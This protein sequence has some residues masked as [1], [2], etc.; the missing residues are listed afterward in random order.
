[1]NYIFMS[2][3]T[4]GWT[5]RARAVA[6][7]VAAWLL[8]GCA[9]LQID[10]DVYKGPL[11]NDEQIQM[12]QFAS[13]AVAAKP[14]LAHLRNDIEVAFRAERK[15]ASVAN[16]EARHKLHKDLDHH[17]TSME[18]QS[19]LATFINGALL[20]Y[21]DLGHPVLRDLEQTIRL[22]LE[23]SLLLGVG[24]QDR[25]L[26]DILR[27]AALEPGTDA[28]RRAMALALARFLC[29]PGERA[30][31]GTTCSALS[32][33]AGAS[34]EVGNPLRRYAG[35]LYAACRNL[36]LALSA[37]SPQAAA[38]RCPDVARSNAGFAFVGDPVNVRALSVLLL[39]AE[40][41]ELSERLL[42]LG[43]AFL[44]ARVHMRSAFEA[45]LDLL[46]AVN[47]PVQAGPRARLVSQLMQ[48][49]ITACVLTSPKGR[50]RQHLSE[51]DR[52]VA[53]RLDRLLQ[54]NSAM[55]EWG[56]SEF[57]RANAAV[58]DVAL[59]APAS[60]ARVF[61]AAH[62]A[63][64]SYSADDLARC[65]ALLKDS[66]AHQRAASS[67]SRQFGA[68]RG[69]DAD[70][71]FLASLESVKLTLGEIQSPHSVAGFDRARL[72]AGIDSLTRAYLQEKHDGMAV[73]GGDASPT[74]RRLRETLIAFAERVLFVS[75]SLT[76]SVLREELGMARDACDLTSLGPLCS[77][78]RDDAVSRI[79]PRLGLVQ[80]LGNT[81][82]LYA[83]DLVRRERHRDGQRNAGAAEAHA[84]RAASTPGLERQAAYVEQQIASELRAATE[85]RD[86]AQTTSERS[87]RAVA[88]AEQDAQATKKLADQANAAAVDAARFAQALAHAVRSTVPVGQR[89]ALVL[90]GTSTETAAA[91]Q[92]DAAAAEKSVLATLGSAPEV[93]VARAAQ[94]MH[95][96]LEG[97]SEAATGERATR[98]RAGGAALGDHA[99]AFGADSAPMTSAQ[100][101]HAY[102]ALLQ[103]LVKDAVALAQLRV[104]EAKAPSATANRQTRMHQELQQR[105]Q[106]DAGTVKSVGQNMQ[107][108]QQL[109]S[110]WQAVRRHAL[111]G[112]LL[113]GGQDAR[114]LLLAA[115]HKE[116]GVVAALG[117]VDPDK[118]P[119]QAALK[120]LESK[121]AA[122]PA[123]NPALD[124]YPALRKPLPG[125]Q[126][127]QREVF[128]SV[129]A[130][131]RQRRVQA[132]AAGLTQA[133]TNLQSAIDAAYD[134]RTA[135]IFLRPASE[136]LRSVYSAPALQGDPSDFQRNM[137]NDYLDVLR[138]RFL[139]DDAGNALAEA[140]KNIERLHW[141]TIN[142]VR[143]AG[144]GSTNYVLAKDDVGNWYVKTY[145]ADPEAVIKSAQSLA[146]FN[147]GR[148]ID[149][150]LLRKL[151]LQRELDD[152]KT[153]GSRRQEIR[154]DLKD[155]GK[156]ESLGFQR[157]RDQLVSRYRDQLYAGAASLQSS[158]E[159]LDT[160][161]QAKV[162]GVLADGG[163]RKAA[164]DV[165]ATQGAV[166]ASARQELRTALAVAESTRQQAVESAV[167]GAL[168]TLHSVG[169]AW[170]VGLRGAGGID[171]ARQ[172]GAADAASAV[173]REALKLHGT[174]HKRAL[175]A[176]EEG[177]KLVGQAR[178]A[179]R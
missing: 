102:R 144:G 73:A 55:G 175:V 91:L 64:L 15:D 134:S 149:V 51:P 89:R 173:A 156:S 22:A 43:S 82:V 74:E 119:R 103:Q 42:Q 93:T 160:A 52:A 59:Q 13:L 75:N 85:Q 54:V 155:A 153:D 30:P 16:P 49:M 23:Q 99:A 166:L 87:T 61:R 32:D 121:L 132:L 143:L 178:S 35:A 162:D 108:A 106:A 165:M 135:G 24:P 71:D 96:W 47:D 46:D 170:S 124:P 127:D 9:A 88:Q 113:A 84:A 41:P 77:S 150:D 105:G 50:S 94:A 123:E 7:L 125:Q 3:E 111:T 58:V 8:C 29:P 117:A 130:E 112:A 169:S 115:V 11:T 66:P 145:E 167:M 86:T 25:K 129:I 20:S 17:H 147:Y 142:T 177:I 104:E 179:E 158:V 53:E 44:Q 133:A 26:A 14:L 164:G 76:G 39:G 38:L 157:V 146:L 12:R 2:L 97:Q 159:R 31:D 4:I 171:K 68:S 120:I 116:V 128:D 19:R 10:V 60:A 141:Q 1:M 27:L 140:R 62:L 107:A 63:A 90:P 126:P 98:L 161:A 137:L 57:A 136:Y 21:E 139:P 118:A 45:A 138:P 72:P 163:E 131:L 65:D 18:L 79:L 40:R 36:R 101:L 80:T 56:R 114:S 70:Q 174:N 122:L 151:K 83:N 154:S 148:R 109:Q 34:A 110:A 172:I 33:A 48:P 67:L 92:A 95:A 28:P 100:V 152:P 81:L 5:R 6:A 78:L 37:S 176:L 69:P 168:R